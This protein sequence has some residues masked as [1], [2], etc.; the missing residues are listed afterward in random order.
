MSWFKEKR[1]WFEYK[2]T[3]PRLQDHYM[4]FLKYTY[5]TKENSYEKCAG[6]TKDIYM[7]SIFR[8]LCISFSSVDFYVINSNEYRSKSIRQIV[9]ILKIRIS[10]K[11]CIVLLLL[12]T[13]MRHTI[14]K[15][16]IV[17]PIKISIQQIVFGHLHFCHASK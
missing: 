17:F 14:R 6:S 13:K 16:D 5:D 8:F 9:W 7:L 2:Y 15:W 4:S 12:T 1:A 11:L 10:T 3:L